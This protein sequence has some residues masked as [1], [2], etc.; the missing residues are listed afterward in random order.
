[1]SKPSYSDATLHFSRRP[2]LAMIQRYI[3]I[4]VRNIF[5]A[6][7]YFRNQN[8][9]LCT[10]IFLRSSAYRIK[11]ETGIAEVKENPCWDN[12]TKLL[13]INGEIKANV[14]LH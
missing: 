12:N 2:V 1:M 4:Y 14:T 11:P 6:G 9:K 10:D 13:T 8:R 3:G 5:Q 7:K